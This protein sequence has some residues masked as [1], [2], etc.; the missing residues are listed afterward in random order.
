MC[1][2]AGRACME[3]RLTLYPGPDTDDNQL[4]PYMDA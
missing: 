4:L 1:R 3:Y 2:Q